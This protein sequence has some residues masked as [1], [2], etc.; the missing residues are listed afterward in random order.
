MRYAEYMQN[1]WVAQN[2]GF[3]QMVLHRW[4]EC[5]SVAIVVECEQV[6]CKDG[7]Q[8]GYHQLC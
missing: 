3:R 8:Q 7:L 2:N 1:Q 5:K 4:K 6:W